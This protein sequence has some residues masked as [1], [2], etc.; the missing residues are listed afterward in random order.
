LNI[1]ELSIILHCA[2]IVSFAKN[3]RETP[4]QKTSNI[5][6]IYWATRNSCKMKY[7]ITIAYKIGVSERD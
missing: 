5:W 6:R 7:I 1:P 4:N 3:W 2:D